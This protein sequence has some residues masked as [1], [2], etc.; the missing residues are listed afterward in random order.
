MTAQASPAVPLL[1]LDLL[2]TLVAIADTGNFSA[3]ADAVFRTPSAISMQVKKIEE[4]VGAPVFLRDSRRVEVTADGAFLVEHARRMLALNR[5]AMARFVAPEVAGV[6]RV[7]APDFIAEDVLPA[8]LRAFSETHPGITVDVVVEASGQMVKLV[9]TGDLDFAMI[10]CLEAEIPGELLFRERLV[11]AMR[12]GGIAA[13]QKPLPV[14]VWDQTCAWRRAGI[15]RLEAQD[16]EW[17]LAFQSSH[18]A[19]QR[20]AILADLAVAPVSA[21]TLGGDIVEVPEHLGLPQLPDY[22]VMLV[23]S[24]GESGPAKA[25]IDHVRSSFARN[26]AVTS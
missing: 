11:W 3:A 9:Q 23:K 15:S 12:Q 19:G 16:R 17:R 26:H 20:S 2:R 4:I 21:S 18:I 8:M 14:S 13:E 5:I 10:T 24:D 25:A 6:V 22:V 7:G 1:E